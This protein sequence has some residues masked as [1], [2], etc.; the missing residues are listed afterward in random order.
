MTAVQDV[1]DLS[2]HP[3][4]HR[5]IG[6]VLRHSYQTARFHFNPFLALAR[7]TELVFPNGT[8]PL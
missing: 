4:T 2:R 7:S 3:L 5:R 8:V 1:V 6:D